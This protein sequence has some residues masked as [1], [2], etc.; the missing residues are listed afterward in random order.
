LTR[1]LF[2]SDLSRESDAAFEHARFLSRW[3]RGQLLLYHAVEMPRHHPEG[4]WDR[5]DEV[6]QR[7]EEAARAHLEKLAATVDVETRVVLES[8]HS[9]HRAL[10][11]IIDRERI[12]LAVMATHGRGGLANLLVGS[13][14]E[15][16]VQHGR[17]SVLCIREP[18]H[19]VH[20]P[21]QQVLVP[22]DLSEASQRPFPL[23]VRLARKFQARIMT[24]HVTDG[25]EEPSRDAVAE[26]MSGHFQGL[27][28]HHRVVAGRDWRQIVDVAKRAR[29]DL[30][31]MATHGHHGIA[32]AVLGS[33]TERVVRH[34]PCPVR[35][36]RGE[37]EEEAG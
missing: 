35:V 30:I 4:L 34:A 5:E 33:T 6:R 29:I 14:T 15:R 36:S 37:L 23:A 20:I 13:V 22:T 32:D 1:I 25:D 11:E 26:A 7:A 18:E 24:L 28:V 8:T 27:E 2:P 3:L 10:I 17:C 21:Y 16:V 19:G 31:E 9:A 12:D